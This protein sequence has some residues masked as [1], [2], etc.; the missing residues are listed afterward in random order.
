MAIWSW[1]A[2]TL[3]S[4]PEDPVLARIALSQVVVNVFY[5]FLENFAFLAENNVFVDLPGLR[6]LRQNTV[7]N[8]W[9]V[10]S[11]RFWLAHVLLDIG[12]LGYLRGKK[13]PENKAAE[14]QRQ[15]DDT[16]WWKELVVNMA[17]TP[18][19]L[20][21]SLESTPVHSVVLGLCGTVAGLIGLR[22]AWK[23]TA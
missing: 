18:V 12:R 7:V 8:K 14:A 21:W 22:D 1:G 19:C 2:S 3:Q 6:Q 20:N 11:S 23:A 13:A 17:W 10:W 9:N 5:Q 4:P 16:E 15:E